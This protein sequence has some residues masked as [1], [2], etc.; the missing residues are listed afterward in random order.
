MQVQS[1]SQKERKEKHG[2]MTLKSP[3]YIVARTEIDLH[4]LINSSST[5]YEFTS[6]LPWMRHDFSDNTIFTTQIIS[7]LHIYVCLKI[8]DI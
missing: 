7:D 3:L 5:Y 4:G 8:L 1:Y 2:K 6:Y